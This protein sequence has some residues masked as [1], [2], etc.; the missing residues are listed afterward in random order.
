MV[1]VQVEQGC[2]DLSD[3]VTNDVFVLEPRQVGLDHISQRA[4]VH[5]LKKDPILLFE[6]VALEHFQ[7]V[8]VV[9]L[10]HEGHF[11]LYGS[12]S[13]LL[14]LFLWY[15]D[16]LESTLAIIILVVTE[17]NFAITSDSNLFDDVVAKCRVLALP[18]LRVG[19]QGLVV[20]L[21][22]KRLLEDKARVLQSV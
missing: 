22:E 3:E 10:H 2:Q 16:E 1:L 14:V 21:A 18:N 20:L 11:V 4:T 6:V 17:E 9:A 19:H 8:P 15:R 12:D 7:N 5:V 13:F